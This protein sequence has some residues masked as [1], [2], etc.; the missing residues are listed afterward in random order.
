VG[1]T[2]LVLPY[3]NFLVLLPL[4]F[5]ECTAHK[6]HSKV[7]HYLLSIQRKHMCFVYLVDSTVL[8]FFIL[9]V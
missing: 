1:P 5:V 2:K 9:Q 8:L 7:S 4:D 3:M 6:K